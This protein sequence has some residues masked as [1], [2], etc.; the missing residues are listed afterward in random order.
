MHQEHPDDIVIEQGGGDRDAEVAEVI[1][2]GGKCE[3]PAG[4]A[5]RHLAESADSRRDGVTGHDH[6]E[7]RA[8]I[9]Q[10]LRTRGDERITAHPGEDHRR[11]EDPDDHAHQRLTGMRPH[12][13]M[14]GHEPAEQDQQPE[15]G[16]GQRDVGGEDIHGRSRLSHDLRT[17]KE[18]SPKRGHVGTV[19]RRYE[20]SLSP[21]FIVHLTSPILHR[22][23][24][25]PTP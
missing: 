23:Y 1:D 20:A 21:I 7:P 16:D 14:A 22:G 9:E 2:P 3:G 13:A 15:T 24:R 11:E 10:R 8:E 17:G 12:P 5:G 6:E 19:T 18:K 25:R 4:R